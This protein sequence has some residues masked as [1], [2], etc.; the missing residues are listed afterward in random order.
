[1]L[2]TYKKQFKARFSL[3][4]PD[5]WE[6]DLRAYIELGWICD[7]LMPSQIDSLC[8][9]HSFSDFTEINGRKII[10][11]RFPTYTEMGAAYLLDYMTY[12]NGED[13]P[14]PPKLPCPLAVFHFS[15]RFRPDGIVAVWNDRHI[16]TWPEKPDLKM[17]LAAEENRHRERQY[18]GPGAKGDTMFCSKYDDV[19]A[20]MFSIHSGIGAYLWQHLV[21][22]RLELPPPSQDEWND[23]WQKDAADK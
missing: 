11:S 14:R 21:H 12:W 23:N 3:P 13:Y 7:K 16:K 19:S 20:F 1:M 22:Q 2:A 17:W 9:N 8:Q 6:L 4:I 18:M 15:A 5:Y 10:A